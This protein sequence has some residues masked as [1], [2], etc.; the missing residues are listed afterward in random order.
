MNPRIHDD[1]N[2]QKLLQFTRSDDFF[3]VDEI[4]NVVELY[5]WLTFK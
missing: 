2:S 1:L 4:D 3:Q 5:V